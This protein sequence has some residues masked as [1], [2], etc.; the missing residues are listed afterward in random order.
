M[1]APAPVLPRARSP[2]VAGAGVPARRARRPRWLLALSLAVA[3]VLVAPLAFLL[4][5]AHGAGTSTIVNLIFRS[6]T[7]TLVWNTVR[8]TVVV[9]A[10]CAVIGTAA[11]WFV[12]RTDLPGRRVW[13]VLVVVPLAIPDFVV[14]FG[15]SSLST[16]VEGFRGA[17]LVMTLAVYPLVYLPVAASLRNA[18]PGQEELARSLG[19]GR[20]ATFW[21]VTIG[22]ARVAILGGCL[23]VALVLLAE[24]GA[25]EIVGYQT[26]TTEIFTE[27][28]VSFN[29]ASASALSL[30][31]VLLSLVALSG[32][33]AAR[34]RG[35]GRLSR[36]G[37]LAQRVAAPQRLG[38]AKP[39]VLVGFVALVGLALG[40]PIGASV[41]WMLDAGHS[42]LAG[43]SLVNAAWHTASYS[44]VAAAL[45]TVMALPVAL[46]AL[47]HRGRG[48]QLLERSTYL[49]LAMP[50][51]VIAL[52]LSYF[53]ERYANGFLYQ[54]AP[55][56][57]LAYAI[58]FF[59]LALVGVRASVAQAP[60]GLEDV[61]RSL[62]QRRLSVLWRVT[63]PLIGPGLAAAFCLVFLSA[64]TELTATLILIPTGVQTLATQFWAYQQNL[65]YGQAAPFALAIIAIAAVP[66]YVLGRFFD[67]LPSRALTAT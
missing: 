50:G 29:V 52:A 19:A 34:G 62:G 28:D 38:R 63:L 49:V 15:W 18:D 66:S 7:A 65:A 53:T 44:A 17:V 37:P 9:T 12:E 22:Q 27:F 43:V 36:S 32:E 67:R 13:A 40:V 57:V 47:R 33:G 55:L 41:Y 30:V 39:V 60:V 4:I 59:P 58:M 6:L 11:A 10:L 14:S 21:R 54:G 26:F 42:F 2:Q 25:F 45:A 20:L 46:L 35:R 16:W 1:S 56:L 3:L 23:L 24:Y 64:A 48:Y 8:L 61:A 31:L 51:L 5:E